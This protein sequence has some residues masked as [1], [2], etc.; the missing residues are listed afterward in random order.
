MVS[1][2][3]AASMAAW[4]VAKPPEPTSRKRPVSAPSTI[5]TPVRLSVPSAPP[6]VTTQPAWSPAVN[7]SASAVAAKDAAVRVAV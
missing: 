6:V 4:M 1:P 3:L 5:S 2:L 7:G